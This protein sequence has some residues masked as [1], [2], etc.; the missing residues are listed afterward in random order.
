MSQRGELIVVDVLRNLWSKSRDDSVGMY[1]P[2]TT[3][4]SATRRWRC[5]TSNVVA[6]ATDVVSHAYLSEEPNVVWQL[7]HRRID[8]AM[9]DSCVRV[10]PS[11]LVCIF[12]ST[13]CNVLLLTSNIDVDRRSP[14]NV[15]QIE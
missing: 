2:F 11:R 3:S 14:D 4:T 12:D 15:L 7:H 6:D 9:A 5:Q 8:G 10:T 1:P 13:A